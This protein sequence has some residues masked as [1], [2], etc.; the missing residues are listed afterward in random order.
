MSIFITQQ[1]KKYADVIIPR[2]ADNLV[3]VDLIV[4]HIQSKLARVSN[5]LQKRDNNTRLILDSFD[6]DSETE[7]FNMEK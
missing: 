1:S 3:A 4:Q 6:S 2:G 5:R 7:Q